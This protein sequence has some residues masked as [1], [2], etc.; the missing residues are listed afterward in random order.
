MLDALKFPLHGHFHFEHLHIKHF[1]VLSNRFVQ[2]TQNGSTKAML[3]KLQIQPVSI[4]LIF[5]IHD[6]L[7]YT[8]FYNLDLI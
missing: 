2:C 1:K 3:K 4:A 6:Q 7:Y 8:C 5:Y